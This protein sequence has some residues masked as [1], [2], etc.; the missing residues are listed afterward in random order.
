LYVISGLVSEN[1]KGELPNNM[2]TFFIEFLGSEFNKEQLEYEFGSNEKISTTKEAVSNTLTIPQLSE[3]L[4]PKNIKIAQR[5]SIMWNT[6]QQKAIEFGN[7]IHE[8]LAFVKTINDIDLAI[9]KAIENG[10]IISSQK[11]EVLATI[12]EI[13]NHKELTEYFSEENKVMNEQTI[14]QKHGNIVKPDR[15]SISKDK[16]VFL[17]DYKT[18]QHLPKHKTQLENYQKSIED[19]G[20]KVEKKSLIYIGETIEVL[21]L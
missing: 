14:I 1:S 6:K 4:N 21:H 19:M 7:I 2:A 3:T 8:I 18:G 17:L 16:K 13:V 12:Y 5:E 15:M 20:F 11:E 10:L 9:T